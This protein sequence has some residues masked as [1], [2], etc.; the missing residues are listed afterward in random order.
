MRQ[1]LTAEDF[2]M[3]K[4]GT[5]CISCFSS[6]ISREKDS[7]LSRSRIVQRFLRDTAMNGEVKGYE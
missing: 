5:V 7:L 1:M 2:A 6:C 3:L 4:I